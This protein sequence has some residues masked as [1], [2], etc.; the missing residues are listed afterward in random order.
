M[1]HVFGYDGQKINFIRHS[2]GRLHGRNIGIDEQRLHAFLAQRFD[3]LRSRVIELARLSNAEAARPQDQHLLRPWGQFGT[4]LV[5]AKAQ[6]PFQSLFDGEP[7]PFR[8]VDHDV[9]KNIEQAFQIL[10]PGRVLGMELYG[11]VR[12]CGVYNTF[13]RVIVSVG[14][15][16]FPIGWQLARVH[17]ESMILHSHVATTCPTMRNRLIVAAISVTVREKQQFRGETRTTNLEEIHTDTY[18]ILYVT[19]PAAMHSN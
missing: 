12:E 8:V 11:E 5:P 19:Q 17:G 9:Q 3:R 4:I 6:F 15:K 18:F 1:F 13:V 2:F 10:G 7:S 14:K 16:W